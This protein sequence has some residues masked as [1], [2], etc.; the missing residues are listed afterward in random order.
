[1]PPASFATPPPRLRQHPSA[2]RRLTHA[3]PLPLLVLAACTAA[4]P[5]AQPSPLPPPPVHAPAD[6]APAP[7]PPVE[8]AL[9]PAPWDQPPLSSAEAPGVLLVQWRQAENRAT[10]A[11]LAP[12]SLEPHTGARVR[13]AQFSGGWAIA[14]DLPG[15]RSAFGIAGTGSS[16]R[17]IPTPI[18]LICCAGSM[19][20]RLATA[21]RAERVPTSSLICASPAS[22]AYTTCGPT[23]DPS[24]SSNCWNGSGS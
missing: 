20:A 8:E 12:V 2:M 15:Q 13:A 4:Q 7:A 5:P 1:M 18:G 24:T 3:L 10:C 14:Y 9:A 6:P 11:P 17:T 21:R 19:E 22:S 16:A 23:W